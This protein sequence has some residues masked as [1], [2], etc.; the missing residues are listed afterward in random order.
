M[1]FIDQIGQWIARRLAGNH[2]SHVT[3][4]CLKVVISLLDGVVDEDEPGEQTGVARYCVS[5]PSIFSSAESASDLTG[6]LTGGS[7]AGGA[8]TSVGEAF[9]VAIRAHCTELLQELAELEIAPDSQWGERPMQSKHTSS[10]HH[11]FV[12][13]DGSERWRVVAVIRAAARGAMIRAHGQRKDFGVEYSA[14]KRVQVG[15]GEVVAWEYRERSAGGPHTVDFKLDFL[16][17]TRANLTTSNPHHEQSSPR[18]I[19]TRISAGRF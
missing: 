7:R 1:P 9:A 12:F 10:P 14:E 13:R 4:K 17:R 5:M 18:A 8:G 3:L 6:S 11:N 2:G 16:V 19:L 15:A